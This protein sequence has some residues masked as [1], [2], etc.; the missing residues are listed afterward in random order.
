[1]AARTIL[2]SVGFAFGIAWPLADGAASARS[3]LNVHELRMQ[4]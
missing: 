1:M 3:H 2:L 4:P